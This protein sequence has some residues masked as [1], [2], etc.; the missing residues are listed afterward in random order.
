MINITDTCASKFVPPSMTFTHANCLTD[1]WGQNG[2]PGFL[3]SREPGASSRIGAG[4]QAQAIWVGGVSNNLAVSL[5]D[6]RQVEKGHRRHVSGITWTGETTQ[7]DGRLISADDRTGKDMKVGPALPSTPPKPCYSQ[8]S[9]NIHS[10]LRWKEGGSQS[11][12][13]YTC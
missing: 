7:H 12:L 8:C 6:Q 1:V 3:S 11:G 9:Q 10:V 4:T 13:G 5:C 2:E